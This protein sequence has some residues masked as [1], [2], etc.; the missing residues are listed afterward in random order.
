MANVKASTI[1]RMIVLIVVIANQ[2]LTM[3][4]KNPLPFSD[5]E[6]YQY[7]T[8]A[9][10][11]GVTIWAWWKNNSFTK[12]A[13]AADEVMTEL[14]NGTVEDGDGEGETETEETEEK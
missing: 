9:I 8:A 2:T 1:V 10:T 12:A 5:D 3:F 6:V 4:G 7:A 11:I 14:R 13:I